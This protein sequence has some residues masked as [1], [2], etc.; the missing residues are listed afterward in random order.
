M[1]TKLDFMT[2]ATESGVVVA[3][4]SLGFHIANF[5]RLCR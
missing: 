3:I 5:P 4:D 2:A 1:E